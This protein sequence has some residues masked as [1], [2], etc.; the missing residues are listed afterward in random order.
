MKNPATMGMLDGLSN[1][2]RDRR[3]PLRRQRLVPHQRC[4]VWSIDII[5]HQ[6]VLSVVNPHF[7]NGHDV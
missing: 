1:A 7:M 6:E 4:Q 2:P 5:H 3:R